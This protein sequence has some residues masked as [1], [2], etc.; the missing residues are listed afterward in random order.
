MPFVN[1]Q[2]FDQ[3]LSQFARRRLPF[4]RQ[5]LGQ[6][7]NHQSA[8]HEPIPEMRRR[9]RGFGQVPVHFPA[10]LIT[11][12]LNLRTRHGQPSWHGRG[13]VVAIDMRQRLE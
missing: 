4:V 9:Q 1:H 13:S 3:S 7:R 5:S 11:L 6:A 12:R 2:L 8:D 10:P